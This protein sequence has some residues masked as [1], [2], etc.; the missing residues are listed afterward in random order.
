[1]WARLYGRKNQLRR[2]VFTGTGLGI[3]GRSV[4]ILA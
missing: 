1:M 2:G 3:I 4:E